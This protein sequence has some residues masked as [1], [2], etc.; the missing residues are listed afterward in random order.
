MLKISVSH[1]QVITAPDRNVRGEFILSDDHGDRIR[2]MIFS[3]EP[4]VVTDLTEF[5]GREVRVRY[6]I[7]VKGLPEGSAFDGRITIASDEGEFNIPVSIQVVPKAEKDLPVSVRSLKEFTDLAARNDDEAFL[8][9]KDPKFEELLRT[10]ESSYLLPLY[11]GLSGNPKS[12]Q[13]MEEFLVLAG[14]KKA[15]EVSILKDHEEYYDLTEPVEENATLRRSTWGSLHIELSTD[16]D[17]IELPQLAI[18]DSDFVGSVCDLDYIILPE[19]LGEGKRTGHIFLKMP[20]Q[21]LTLSIVASH[22][23]KNYIG[24]ATAAKTNRIQVARAFLNYISGPASP[25][26]NESLNPKGNAFLLMNA[27]FPALDAL[28]RT[29]T[30]GIFPD[31]LLAWIKV[32]EE[33]NKDAIGILNPLRDHDFKQ[34]SLEVRGL[35][36]YLCYRIGLLPLEQRNIPKKLAQYRMRKPD[37]YLLLKLDMLCDPERPNLPVSSLQMMEKAFERGCRSP[38]LYADAIEFLASDDSLLTSLTPFTRQVLYYGARRHLINQGLALRAAFL[39]DN[40]KRYSPVMFRVLSV[41]YRDFPLDGILEAI[42]RLLMKRPKQDRSCFDWYALAIDRDIRMTRLYEYYIETIPEGYQKILP[43]QIRKYFAFN[44]TLSD[45]DRVFLYANITRNRPSDPD[46]YDVYRDKMADFAMKSLKMK[47]MDENYAVLYQ[48]FIQDI[49]DSETAGIMGRLIFTERIYCDDPTVRRV[50]VVHP[51]LKEEESL[52][53]V[54]G[55]ACIHVYTDEAQIFFEDA[56]GHRYRHAMAYNVEALM[57]REPYLESCLHFGC[58][59]SGFL[60]H[61]LYE[62]PEAQEETLPIF[63]AVERSN[64]FTDEFRNGVRRALLAFYLEHEDDYHYDRE[65]EELDDQRFAAADKIS[66]IEVLL[67][68]GFYKRAFKLV[69]IYGAEGIENGQL[70]RLASRMIEEMK[71]KEDE[72]LLVLCENVFKRGKYD[73]RILSYLVAYENAAIGHMTAIREKARE[74]FVE[75]RPLDERILARAIFSHLDLPEAPRILKHYIESGGQR[76][77]IL[78]SMKLMAEN[79]FDSDAPVDEYLGKCLSDAYDEGKTDRTMRVTYL[80][81]LSEQKELTAHQENDVDALME[82][83]R[84]NGLVFQFMQDLPESFVRQYHLMDKVIAEVKVSEGETAVL[85]YR[86]D[87]KDS[88]QTKHARPFKTERVASRFRGTFQKVFTLFYG[89]QVSYFWEIGEGEKKRRTPKQTASCRFVDLTGRSRF[90]RIN[91]MLKEKAEGRTQALQEDLKD[92]M[93]SSFAMKHL[94]RLE[95]DI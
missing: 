3:D 56:E 45:R 26:K 32:L 93:K 14:R 38:F 9:F 58:H 16:A 67:A 34:E 41:S 69:N 54:H 87:E 79:A 25:V 15:V 8:L 89:E 18:E 52:I 47:K 78:R 68:H 17:F 92:Y 4:R 50:V 55:A 5:S 48:N 57:D 91:R 82:D 6:G 37:S 74:F 86:I 81:Y 64:M 24:P 70:V 80:R 19:K 23:P 35:Y 77:L 29:K 84:E 11:K 83:C 20:G 44:E 88:L 33:K 65:I 51:E 13:K 10:R 12:K 60:L 30:D 21:L 22:N 75:T 46:T 53:L 36:E 61:M 40:E 49:E 66:L 71:F 90:Q 62:Y 72:D 1:I 7:D 42:C 39:T 73:E 76:P 85:Y 2:G 95:E 63:K 43:V 31:L 28:K 27:A 59:E 94:F